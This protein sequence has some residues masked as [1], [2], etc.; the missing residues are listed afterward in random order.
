[1]GD[2]SFEARVKILSV[3]SARRGGWRPD[4]DLEKEW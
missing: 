3:W 2:T 1:M 4:V